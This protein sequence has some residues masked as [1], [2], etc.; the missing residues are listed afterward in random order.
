MVTATT[1]PHTHH[2]SICVS[3]YQDCLRVVALGA[4]HKLPDEAIKQFLKFGSLVGSVNNVASRL[5]QLGLCTQ[6]KSKEFARI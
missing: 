3:T 2:I 1:E 4:E 5:V 6:L